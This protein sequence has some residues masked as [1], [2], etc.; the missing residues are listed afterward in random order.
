MKD[1]AWVAEKGSSMRL[2]GCLLA[3]VCVQSDLRCLERGTLSW[4]AMV[5]PRLDA[6][7]SAVH[8]SRSKGAPPIRLGRL[9]GLVVALRSTSSSEA[10]SEAFAAEHG[11]ESWTLL[12]VLYVNLL[13]GVRGVPKGRWRD[14]DATAVSNLQAAVQRVL[15][16]DVS[17]TRTVET[18]EK[19]LSSRFVSY[20]GEEIPR[21]EPL[22]VDQVLPALPPAGHGGSVSVLDWTKGRTRSFLVHPAECVMVDEGQKHPKLQAK[23]HILESDQMKVAEILVERHICNWIEEETVLRYRG[24]KVLNG[25]FGVAKNTSLEDGRP[26]LRV[27]MNLIPSN[28][29]LHQLSG[30]VQDLPGITQYIS[31]VLE[32]NERLQ[33]CQSDMQSAF[34]LFRLP[35]EWQPLLSFNFEV[36]GSQIGKTPRKRYHLACSVLPMGWTSAVSVMQEI[37]QMLIE[38]SGADLNSQVRRTRPLPGWLTESL[39]TARSEKREWFHVY[40]DNFFAGERLE[41]DHPGG[42]A[43]VLHRQVENAWAEAGV[44]TSAKKPVHNAAEVQELGAQVDGAGKML[45]A[46]AGRLIKLLQTTCVVLAKERI[47]RKWLQVL[48]GRWVHVLQ[49]RRAGMSGL[50][51]VWKWSGGKRWV[52]RSNCSLGK[53]YVP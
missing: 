44:L 30:C 36:D 41:E 49:F 10:A 51:Y 7:T 4:L 26:H 27:I 43:C 48:S 12:A 39:K 8:R 50:H 52:G 37:S 1:L 21:M 25:M 40:L 6:G 29:V 46:S 38:K 19:E 33:L 9:E 45:G 42:Q 5:V 20:T 3:W 22:S 16:L 17:V 35:P 32:E 18:V 13:H 28:S 34:Y 2:M 47:P 31:V 53:N 14:A 23:V 24:E 15:R 11:T